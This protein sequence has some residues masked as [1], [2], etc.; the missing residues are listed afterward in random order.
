MSLPCT[1]MS[2]A[3]KQEWFNG[4][5]YANNAGRRDLRCLYESAQEILKY[6]STLAIILYALFQRTVMKVGWLWLKHPSRETIGQCPNHEE[7]SS[8][9]KQVRTGDTKH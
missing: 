9:A 7:V 5:I 3:H 6:S 1:P 4:F 2:G 8:Y